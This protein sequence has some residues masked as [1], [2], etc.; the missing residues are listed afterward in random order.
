MHL[1]A[2]AHPH[3]HWGRRRHSLPQSPKGGNAIAVL[4]YLDRRAWCRLENLQA[5]LP[6]TLPT[7]RKG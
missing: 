6:P 7:E 4:A 3:T 1:P 5:Q 2:V